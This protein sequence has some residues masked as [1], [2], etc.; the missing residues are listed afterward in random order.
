MKKLRTRGFGEYYRLVGDDTEA[1]MSEIENSLPPP[2]AQ[3][4]G[5]S[6]YNHVYSVTERVNEVQK[7][8]AA[9]AAAVAAAETPRTGRKRTTQEDVENTLN[10]RVRW[11]TN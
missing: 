3:A 6:I 4:F 7:L 5:R 2:V 8:A 9:A 11:D 10:K 1:Q